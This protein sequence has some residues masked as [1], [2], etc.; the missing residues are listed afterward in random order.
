MIRPLLLDYGLPA[1]FFITTGFL[2]NRRL[3]YQQKVALCIE[4][5][6]RL[7]GQAATAARNEIA[8]LFNV[9]V[10]GDREL[11][12]R[13]RPLPGRRSPRSTP[14]AARS[15]STPMRTCALSVRI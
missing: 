14:P 11:V 5:Y 2:D 1:T 4:S 10:N 13:L 12:A 15:A 8:R 7:S 9:E 3:F 6:S